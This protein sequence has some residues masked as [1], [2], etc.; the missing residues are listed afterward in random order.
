LSPDPNAIEKRFGHLKTELGFG[1]Q[2][3]FH[4]LRKTVVTILENAGVAENVVADIV[5]PEKTIMPY[6]LYSGGSRSR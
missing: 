4:S 3:V 2:L 5:G 1:P 6:G